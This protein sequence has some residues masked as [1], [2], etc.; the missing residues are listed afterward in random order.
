MEKRDIQEEK[1]EKRYGKEDSEKMNFY[2]KVLYD[3]EKFTYSKAV[4]LGRLACSV[5]K[6]DGVKQE[7]IRIR[8][9]QGE[10][11][12]ELMETLPE[13][14]ARV[15]KMRYGLCEDYP[16]PSTIRKI[17]EVFGITN[18]GISSLEQYALKNLR[19]SRSAGKETFYIPIARENK[20]K[21]DEQRMKLIYLAKAKGI[22]V[23]ENDWK[24][25][26]ELG[27][28]ARAYNCLTRCGVFTVLEL[29]MLTLTK[30]CEVKGVGLK[31][32]MEIVEKSQE[33]G[34]PFT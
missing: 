1:V 33:F 32:Y 13:K 25:I 15:L 18:Q 16:V 21:I 27:L 30:L 17:S 14:Q 20:K 34:V 6:K 19:P 11:L 31:T 7:D 23:S 29:K 3:S 5:L 24:K 12:L 2:R 22:D 8:T 28:S 26:S 4:N 10:K 9:V